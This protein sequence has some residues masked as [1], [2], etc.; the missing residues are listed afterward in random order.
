M[1]DSGPNLP[2]GEI[3]K[4]KLQ[5]LWLADCSSSMDG[6]KIGALNQAIR[7]V[8]P[9]IK[10]LLRKRPECDL[11]MRV[12]KYSSIAEWHVGPDPEPIENFIWNPVTPSGLTHTADAI[13]LLCDELEPERMKMIG[14][15]QF[16]PIC[17]L[18]SDGYCTQS[19]EDVERAIARLNSLYYGEKAI[20][21]AIGVGD[22]S[23]Y[24]EAE[25]L[26]FVNHPEIGVLKSHSPGELI[27]HMKFIAMSS[28]RTASNPV[29]TP[30]GSTG[31]ENQP[32]LDQP[33]WGAP[34]AEDQDFVAF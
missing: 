16:R 21:L 5:F 32:V 31:I 22:E 20:R 34:D 14:R 18:I 7:E 9:E 26:K 2:E 29:N 17:V 3:T 28:I 8:L 25:L 1:A 13:N 27:R 10:D 12:I 11:Q 6:R 33:D 19:E 4:R 23:D 15:K 30:A 24:N